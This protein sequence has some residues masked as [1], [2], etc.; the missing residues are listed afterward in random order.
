VIQY[1]KP[2]HR[3]NHVSYLRNA[4]NVQ[5]ASRVHILRPESAREPVRSINSPIIR[6]NRRVILA[7]TR[8]SVS[9]SSSSSSLSSLSSLS[10]SSSS[11]IDRIKRSR[12]LAI[13]VSADCSE[14]ARR[15]WN[16][17]ESRASVRNVHYATLV[18]TS[19][20]CTETLTDATM[21]H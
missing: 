12:A 7:S 21:C 11:T 13:I 4:R 5:D 1:L 9:S 6:G 15:R 3:E 17:W 16:N 20:S 19:D 18:I 14:R 10:S 8:C 2:A